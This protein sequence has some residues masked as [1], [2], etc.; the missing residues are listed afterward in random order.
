MEPHHFNDLR[1]LSDV[2]LWTGGWDSTYRVLQRALID[3]VTTRP[4]YVVYRGRGSAGKELETMNRLLN[5]LDSSHPEARARVEPLRLIALESIPDFPDIDAAWR[6]V[7][8]T[9]NIGS[10]YGWLARLATAGGW[11]DV[12]LMIYGT[13]RLGAVLGG[14]VVAVERRDGRTTYAL[15][16]GAP[17]PQR[18]L[19]ER[20]TFPLWGVTKIEAVRQ[21]D[22]EGLTEVMADQYWFCFNPKNGKPCG[23]CRPCRFAVADGLGDRVPLSGHLRYGTREALKAIGVGALIKRLARLRS[24]A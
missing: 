23:T 21:A 1:G 7:R 17:E 12:E 9:H 8:L 14:H 22:R 2:T 19:F 11:T 10:Q 5:T 4:C 6:H 20:F 24:I 13:G 16:P 18:L 15:G 3:K